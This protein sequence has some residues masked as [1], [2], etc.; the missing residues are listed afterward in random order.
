[1]TSAA[2]LATGSWRLEV[3]SGLTRPVFVLR[4]SGVSARWAYPRSPGV[5]MRLAL[6]DRLDLSLDQSPGILRGVA[7]TRI[8]L[9][10]AIRLDLAARRTLEHGSL[11]VAIDDKPEIGIG[12]SASR[13]GA[14]GGLAFR[15][16][17]GTLATSLLHEQGHPEPLDA[18]DHLQTRDIASGWSLEWTPA[19]AG[20]RG[21][22]RTHHAE[23]R[24]SA[25]VD[26]A[27][28]SRR[29]HDMLLRSSSVL[30]KAGWSA[31]RWS[32]G[33][34]WED[35]VVDLPSASYFAPFLSWNVFDPSPWGP[36]DQ[37][38]SDQ[39][40]HLAGTIELRRFSAT[41][42]RRIGRGSWRLDLGLDASWWALDPFVVH[43]TTRL[44]FLGLGYSVVADTGVRPRI[45]AW[46]LAP[47]TDLTWDAGFWGAFAAGGHATLPVHL[48]RLDPPATAPGDTASGTD[49]GMRG[50]WSA[51]I[52]WSRSW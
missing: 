37:I 5:S 40:E 34:G 41:A 20:P 24:S 14:E 50:L 22:L 21:S 4:Q 2:S 17:A 11:L 9:G 28:S 51:T 16:Q 30:A 45:R 29:F 3:R 25:S 39:R 26:T 38:L 12:W 46:T 47:S 19:V 27:G 44:A 13:L 43:R 7:A 8:P 48:E 49:G 32:A 36:V 33:I 52:S 18:H 10:E 42:R 6:G 1:V 31:P 23:I 35:H 15:A